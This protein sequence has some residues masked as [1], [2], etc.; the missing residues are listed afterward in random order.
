M[1]GRTPE[2]QKKVVDNVLASLLPPGAPDQFRCVGPQHHEQQQELAWEAH[3]LHHAHH[4]SQVSCTCSRT[5][6]L[7]G[8]Q[9][10]PSCQAHVHHHMPVLAHHRKIFPPTKGSA[11]LNALFASAGFG[12]LVGK[13]ELVEGDVKVRGL[14][15]CCASHDSGAGASVERLQQQQTSRHRVIDNT[16]TITLRLV[17]GA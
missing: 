13:M 6:A 8:P 16:I 11:E 17:G 1:K 12:W 10:P 2:Q 7:H 4:L 3:T 14:L 9:R 5:A 15:G